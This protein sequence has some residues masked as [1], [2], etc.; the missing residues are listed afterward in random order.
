MIVI[1]HPHN[2]RLVTIEHFDLFVNLLGNAPACKGRAD[3][4]FA[5][6]KQG[7]VFHFA[8]SADGK[9][10]NVGT[11]LPIG[12]PISGYSNPVYTEPKTS[13][14]AVSSRIYIV[15]GRTSD[16]TLTSS[17][18]CCDGKQWAEFTQL[19]L[20]A[21]EGA[22]VVK[23]MVDTD[24]PETLWILCPGETSSG[25]QSTLYF[26]ENRGVTWKPMAAEYEAYAAN[27]HLVPTA[28]HS[29]VYDIK[30]HRM[31]FC[32]GYTAE[33]RYTSSIVSGILTQLTFDKRR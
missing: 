24:Y 10:W 4:L 23:Y 15:G 25:V 9:N 33:G 3:S 20:P 28:Y 5:I 12:F 13:L 31:Y 18:W 2:L 22:Q 11:Q 1:S 17:T 8:G 6:V 7:E 27:D 19:Y 29:M 32:G 14:G 30:K 16:G 26:S 21:L